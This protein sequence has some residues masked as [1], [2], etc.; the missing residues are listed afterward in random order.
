MI[1]VGSDPAQQM[2]ERFFTRV[3]H[4]GVLVAMELEP[5]IPKL[6]DGTRLDVV[7]TVSFVGPGFSIPT[8][9][10]NKTTIF[11]DMR[12]PNVTHVTLFG[13]KK[14]QVLSQSWVLRTSDTTVMEHQVKDITTI[15]VVTEVCS[16]I[17]AASAG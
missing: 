13:M 10:I 3:D 15:P 6:A 7:A 11:V 14:F 9:A 1:G 12:L 8:T 16:G 2:S 17:S 5:D 4:I